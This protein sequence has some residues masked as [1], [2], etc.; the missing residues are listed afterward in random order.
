[1]QKLLTLRDLMPL[2]NLSESTI[3][4][5][6]AESRAGVG[7]FPKPI[8]ASKRKLLFNPDEVDRWANCQQR[9]PPEIESASQRTK[10]H[11]AALDRLRSRGVKIAPKQEEQ[12]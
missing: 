5:R 4:R 8:T 10:R 12:K 1:M 11:H 6:I 3:R 2:L 9:A 7:N